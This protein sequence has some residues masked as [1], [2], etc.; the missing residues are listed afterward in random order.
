MKQIIEEVLRNLVSLYLREIGRAGT[1]EW[2]IFATPI[3]LAG[4][5]SEQYIEYALH[6]QCPWRIVGPRG[7][8][9]G[10]TDYFHSAQAP[11]KELPDSEWDQPGASL[12]D[13]RV[14]AF[15]EQHSNHP[16]VVHSVWADDVGS[17]RLNMNDIY[18]IEVFPD[19]SLEGEHWRLF[20]PD[21]EIS[22]F[23]VS[24]RGAEYQ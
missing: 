13:T 12:H 11:Y 1:V 6:L 15:L 5:E 17:I 16:I 23:V 10:S 20:R 19:D 8:V 9:T 4:G 14:I 21:A 3:P 24:G 7:I 22:H 2:L 18:S